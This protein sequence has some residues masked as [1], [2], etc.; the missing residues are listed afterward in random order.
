MNVNNTLTGYDEVQYEKELSELRREK[1]LQY[2]LDLFRLE[3]G[4]MEPNVVS[5][6]AVASAVEKY[7]K[8]GK[9]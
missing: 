5:L 4:Y 7:L 9:E 6:V 3:K 8:D 2:A 1:S